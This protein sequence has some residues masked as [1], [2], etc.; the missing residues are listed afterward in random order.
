MYVPDRQQ[1]E[2]NIG[3]LSIGFEVFLCCLL[4]WS[5][6][7]RPILSFYAPKLF[8][9]QLKSLWSSSLFQICLA[10]MVQCTCKGKHVNHWVEWF[11]GDSWQDLSFNSEHSH[12]DQRQYIQLTGDFRKAA[13]GS[14]SGV[15]SMEG[16]TQAVEKLPNWTCS[17]SCFTDL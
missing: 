4:Y 12:W 9:F 2:V 15:Q 16:G 3:Y 17:W 7:T 8:F 10:E 5:I 14:C 11:Q 1:S 6:L 13:V